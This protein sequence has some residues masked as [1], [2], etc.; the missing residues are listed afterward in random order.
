MGSEQAFEKSVDTE[1]LFVLQCRRSEQ[2][3]EGGQAMSVAFELEYEEFY[4]RLTVVPPVRPQRAPSRRVQHRRVAAAAVVLGLLVLLA[5]P[6]RSLGGSTLAN[7][8]PAA[9]QVYV[10]HAGDTVASIAARV[11]GG[12]VAG[13][14]HALT[15][16]AGSDVLVPGEHLLIP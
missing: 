14:E 13:L 7:A 1:H 6:I 11:G 4:P 16:E 5:L 12:N 15:A 3:F 8:A 10:I 9:G 2:V